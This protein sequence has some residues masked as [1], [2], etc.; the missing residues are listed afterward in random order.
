MNLFERLELLDDPRDAR[1]KKYTLI[2]IMSVMVNY[3]PPK[4]AEASSN[5]GNHRWKLS[6][7]AASVSDAMGFL[8]G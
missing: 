1:G 2:D 5:H 3:H 4:E 6:F 8:C 7:D